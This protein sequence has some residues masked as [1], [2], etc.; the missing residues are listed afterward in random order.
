MKI[1]WI[2]NIA[3]VLLLSSLFLG[4]EGVIAITAFGTVCFSFWLGW[5]ESGADLRGAKTR[6][7]QYYQY[8]R[9]W[10]NIRHLFDRLRSSGLTNFEVK[11]EQVEVLVRESGDKT[12]K[13]IVFASDTGEMI[14]KIATDDFSLG[15]E[16]EYAFI[17]HK[18]PGYKFESQSLTI[19][20]INGVPIPCDLLIICNETDSKKVFFDISDFRY[21]DQGLPAWKSW[22]FIIF[23][24]F[25]IP[26]INKFVDAGNETA[27]IITAWLFFIVLA[28]CI[29]YIFRPY[30]E[31][32]MKRLSRKGNDID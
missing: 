16:T 27:A 12:V 15:I 9:R 7:R 23:L 19:I 6:M 31:G 22:G 8:N 11:P 26:V 17:S 14:V 29:G 20:S 4:I 25:L 18:F 3:I 28:L 1:V 5:R 32:M 10:W 21:S 30:C 24:L 13:A 2:V